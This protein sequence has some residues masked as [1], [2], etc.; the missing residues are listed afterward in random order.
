MVRVRVRAGV[1]VS[2]TLTTVSRY[3]NQ[4]RGR[5][6]PWC[7]AASRAA[8]ACPHS[9]R[10]R[11]RRRR[12]SARCRAR[13]DARSTR[14]VR[15]RVRVRL[16]VRVSS[17]LQCQNHTPNH[18][19]VVPQYAVRTARPRLVRARRTCSAWRL[20]ASCPAPLVR[21]ERRRLLRVARTSSTKAPAGAVRVSTGSR[22]GSS[23]R[24]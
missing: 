7:A 18:M 19:P 3:P 23:T 16:R 21:T 13:S 12:C 24:R 17:S 11:A 6:A 4:R 2:R 14:L 20:G 9:D 8:A 10:D 15:A 5:C 22:P 1:R